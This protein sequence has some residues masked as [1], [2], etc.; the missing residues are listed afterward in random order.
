MNSMHCYSFDVETFMKLADINYRYNQYEELKSQGCKTL[1]LSDCL[2]DLRYLNKVRTMH[3]R[4]QEILVIDAY[5]GHI[6]KILNEDI[7]IAA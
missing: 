7:N 1:T 5:I 6:E 3:F 4:A 2:C